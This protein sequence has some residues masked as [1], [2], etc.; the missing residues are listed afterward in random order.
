[1]DGTRLRRT[2]DPARQGWYSRWRAVRFARHLG[3][4]LVPLLNPLTPAVN[5][6]RPAASAPQA[7]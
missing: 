4:A 5:T 7:A 3:F 2:L 1:M 6:C